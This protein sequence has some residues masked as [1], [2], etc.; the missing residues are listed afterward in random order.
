ME[1]AL[2]LITIGN[3]PSFVAVLEVNESLAGVD[4]VD[5]PLQVFFNGERSFSV[6]WPLRLLALVGVLITAG[7]T[8]AKLS[9]L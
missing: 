3:L 1:S 9:R 7:D 5:L 4:K 2:N 8:S 6:V